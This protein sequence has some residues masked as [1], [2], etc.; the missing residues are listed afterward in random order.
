MSNGPMPMQ[1]H[2]RRVAFLFFLFG[3]FWASLAVWFWSAGGLWN[4]DPLEFAFVSWFTA[5][6]IPF[7]VAASG[8]LRFKRWARPV[9]IGLS[10]LSVPIF[11][12]GTAVGVYGLW[13]LCS[14]EA[15]AAFSPEATDG[16]PE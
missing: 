12:I 7:L 5:V 10:A 16:F 3:V 11:P 2:V 13:A 1:R 15:K 8:L 14:P 9:A 4:W 6:A